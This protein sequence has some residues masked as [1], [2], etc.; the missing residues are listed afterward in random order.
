MAS[1][2]KYLD[3]V[4]EWRRAIRAGETTIT[5]IAE[6]TG[7]CYGTIRLNVLGLTELSAVVID[8]EPPL[9]GTKFSASPKRYAY[10]K[11]RG[12]AGL[13]E[14]EVHMVRAGKEIGKK[15]SRQMR[16]LIRK[17]RIYK[18]VTETTA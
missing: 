14:D 9:P 5:R 7:I 13:T 12:D 8:G 1:P 17:R 18:W 6:E 15:I 3:R 2:T 16:S 10:I 4:G 11:K